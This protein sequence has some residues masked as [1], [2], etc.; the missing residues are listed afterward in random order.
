[1]KLVRLETALCLK[2]YS[3]VPRHIFGRKYPDNCSR[4]VVIINLVI[5][6]DAL[7][8]FLTIPIIILYK[9]IKNIVNRDIE[10]CT[11]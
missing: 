9:P 6:M 4:K 3:N 2:K 8:P 7:S 1:M 11:G 5:L 10:L